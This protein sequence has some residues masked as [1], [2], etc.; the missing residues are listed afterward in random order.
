MRRTQKNETL[1]FVR[2]KIL[3]KPE[4]LFMS[5]VPGVTCHVASVPSLYLETS[6]DINLWKH[7]PHAPLQHGQSHTLPCQNWD[8]KIRQHFDLRW[9]SDG[10]SLRKCLNNKTFLVR[11]IKLRVQFRSPIAFIILV[12]LWRWMTP[13]DWVDRPGL[14]GESFV[15]F[16]QFDL[17]RYLE[18]LLSV[19]FKQNIEILDAYCC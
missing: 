15:I 11:E 8:L 13:T 19:F 14:I 18:Q 12:P 2:Q 7:K 10:D 4:V 17:K 6:T 16:N 5:A 9:R 3:Q 1:V